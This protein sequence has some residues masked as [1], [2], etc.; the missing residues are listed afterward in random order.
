M[1]VEV[2]TQ[3]TWLEK[4]EGQEMGQLKSVTDVTVAIAAVVTEEEGQ[5][6]GMR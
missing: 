4:Q 5:T 6:S 2:Q 3:K 1:E